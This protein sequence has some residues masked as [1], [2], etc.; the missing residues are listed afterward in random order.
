MILIYLANQDYNGGI[1][2]ITQKIQLYY[3]LQEKYKN[4]TNKCNKETDQHQIIVGELKSD[5]KGIEEQHLRN[6]QQLENQISDIN[7][8][9]QSKIKLQEQKENQIQSKLQD[10]I[11]ESNNNFNKYKLLYDNLQEKYED[12]T[13]KYSK[14]TDKHQIIVEKL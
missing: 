4:L 9:H 13:S 7:Q 10:E 6:V 12:L 8:Q 2:N 3:K 11:Q 14:E 5:I 1:I